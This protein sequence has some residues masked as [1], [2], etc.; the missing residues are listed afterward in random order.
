MRRRNP[1]GVTDC[2]SIPNHATLKASTW[3]TIITHAGI[4]REDFLRAYDES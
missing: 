3:R 4:A 1:E 2:V